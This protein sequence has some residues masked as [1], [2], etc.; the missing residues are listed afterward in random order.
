MLTDG[1]VNGVSNQPPLEVVQNL[2]GDR[3]RDVFLRLQAGGPQ[4]RGEND[5]GH[6]EQ[7]APG[8][9]LCFENIERGPGYMPIGK[10]LAQGLLIYQPAAGA[11]DNAYAGFGLCQ[12]LP[13][14]YPMGLARLAECAR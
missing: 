7:R 13:V 4:V 14:Q 11:V 5:V 6:I 12:G 8:G 1:K 9:R 10:K 2:G 3:H